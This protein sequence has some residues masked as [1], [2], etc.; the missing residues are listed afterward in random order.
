MIII[1]NNVHCLLIINNKALSIHFI[2]VLI[3]NH[4]KIIYQG[5]V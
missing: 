3:I 4:A 2:I 1:Y 5:G